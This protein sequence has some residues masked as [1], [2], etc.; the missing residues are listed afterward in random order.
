M[1]LIEMI[2]KYRKTHGI[3]QREFARMCGLSNAYISILEKGINPS[4][5]KP[6]T[7]NLQT[8][9]QIASAMGMSLDDL[10]RSVDDMQV[11]IAPIPQTPRK[12]NYSVSA[13]ALTLAKTFDALDQHGQRVVSALAAEELARV[14]AEKE[15]PKKTIPLMENRLAAGY[16]DPDFDN[17]TSEYEIPASVH[18]DF[19]IHVHGTSMEPYLHDGDI[20]LGVN[21]KPKHG[22]IGAFLLNGEYLVKQYITDHLGNVYLLSLNRKEADKDIYLMKDN[23]DYFELWTFGAII[24]DKKIPLPKV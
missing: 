2:K 10:L 6:A 21:R 9:K 17:G 24:T 3:S 23:R 4:T 15:V 1:T 14:D 13:K 18:A 19:A 5:G 11:E 20:A 7:P 16:A 22:E 8:L 12:D